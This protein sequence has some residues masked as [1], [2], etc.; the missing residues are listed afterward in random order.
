MVRNGLERTLK[1]GQ[2]EAELDDINTSLQRIMANTMHLLSKKQHEMDR[3]KKLAALMWDNPKKQ[4]TVET[5]TEEDRPQ[6]QD[7]PP[8]TSSNTI[9]D[10]LPPD[11]GTALSKEL[12]NNVSSKNGSTEVEDVNLAKQTTSQGPTDDYS[13]SVSERDVSTIISS[14]PLN[15]SILSAETVSKLGRVRQRET[16]VRGILSEMRKRV[17]WAATDQSQET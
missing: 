17:L 16:K 14:S 10:A 12:E 5:R 3:W 13:Q 11:V 4:T 1:I 9:P 6:S 15:E 8:S 2:C 7:S